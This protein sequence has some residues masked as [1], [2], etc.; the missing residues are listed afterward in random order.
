MTGAFGDNLFAAAEQAA[1]PLNLSADELELLKLLGTCINYNGY[2]ATVDDLIFNPE[3]LYHK[4]KP[5]ADPFDFINND[6]AYQQLVNGYHEDMANAAALVPEYETDQ[7]AIMILENEKWAKRVGGVFANQLA[8]ENPDRAHA[9]L[10]KDGKGGYVVS[11]RAPLSNKTGAD[12]LCRQFHSG[13]G[14]KAAAGINHLPEE[15]Y[16]QFMA[17]FLS[18][19]ID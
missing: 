3:D 19:F 13:G 1:K 17:A 8:Q 6:P 11:V 15:E 7:H 4:I 5:Y 18:A 16:D 14:R 2:G 10:T 12:E 9:M